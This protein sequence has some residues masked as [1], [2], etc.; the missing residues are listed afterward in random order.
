[1]GEWKRPLHYGDVT[2]EV[3]AVREAA[4]LI[5][6]STLGKLEVQGPDAGAFLD[7]LH[8]NRFSDLREGRVRY[9]AMLDDAGIILDDGTVARLG[10]ERFFVSTTT[11]TIDAVEQWFRWWLAGSRPRRVAVDQRHRPARRGQPRRARGARDP[12]ARHRRGRVARGDALPR[13]RGGDRRGHPGDPAADRVRGRARLRDPRARGLRRGALGR[14]DGRPARTWGSRPFGV[15]AQRV[16]RLEKQHA[17]VGQDTDALSS[18]LEAGMGWLVKAEKPDFIGRDAAAAVAATRPARQV[19]TGFEI[20]AG[21]MPDGGRRDRPRR[22]ADRPRDEPQVEPDARAARSASRG[23]PPRRRSRDAADGPSRRRTRRADE[24]RRRAH[25]AVLRS[26]RRAAPVMTM[27][28]P[29]P[30]RSSPIEAVHARLGARWRSETERWPVSYGDE[31][32]EARVVQEGIALAEPGPYEKLIVRGPSTL[33]D[34]RWLGLAAKVGSLEPARTLDGINAWV[35]SDDEAY[36]VRL[37]GAGAAPGRAAT[38][39]TESLGEIATKLRSAGPAVV[40]VSS[41][42]TILR[43][44]GRRLPALMQELCSVDTSVG[45]VADCRDRARRRS[46][47]CGW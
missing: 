12:G 46:S 30:V 33:V 37:A 9:R 11:G 31:A 34:L 47:G 38:V 41:A 44:V 21:G 7:W 42:Y 15:E 35:T 1:M 25:E 26:R 22:R 20:V 17:I 24:L 13:R 27:R 39:A 23:C 16:L 2:A 14:A 10:P 19:L 28:L 32:G 43:L 6:V 18:P 29:A 5:D 4:G 36:L 8:P 40:D 3:R 45:A